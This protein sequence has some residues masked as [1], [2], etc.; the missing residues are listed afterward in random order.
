MKYHIEIYDTA[1]Y[2]LVKFVD[3]LYTFYTE[4]FSRILLHKENF[5]HIL[6][7]GPY[8]ISKAGVTFTL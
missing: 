8:N 1:T 6:S 4:K 2:W 7:H 3:N 5:W